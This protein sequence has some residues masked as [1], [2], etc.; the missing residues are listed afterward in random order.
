MSW[1]PLY[2][3]ILSVYLPGFLI[4][5]KRPQIWKYTIIPFFYISMFVFCAVGSCTVFAGIKIYYTTVDIEQGM[6]EYATLLVLQPILYYIVLFHYAY[7]KRDLGESTID[8][9]RFSDGAIS[10]LLCAYI[11]AAMIYYY[12]AVGP[13]LIFYVLSGDLANDNTVAMR[14]EFLY[15]VEYWNLINVGIT[16]FPILLLMHSYFIKMNDKIQ[17][18]RLR[19]FYF[20]VAS[21]A[22]I[23]SGGKSSIVGIA[24]FL[25]IASLVNRKL[26][27]S[28]ASK[29]ILNIKNM[30]YASIVF[31]FLFTAYYVAWE[32]KIDFY[33][34][35][36]QLYYRICVV[37][38]EVIAASVNYA[39]ENGYFGV[40]VLPTIQGLLS[41]TQV[42]LSF[43]MMD[44]VSGYKNAG[45]T[46]VPFV[47]EGYLGF[48]WFGAIIYCVVSYIGLIIV[49][50]VLNKI[51][52]G[53]FKYTLTAYYCYAS[54]QL[55]YGGISALFSLTNVSFFFGIAMLGLILERSFSRPMV[56]RLAGQ[57]Q[58]R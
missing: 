28:N 44:Y 38:T 2:I 24:A 14:V 25:A 43:T 19:F 9:Y 7:N 34:F 51:R 33:G 11:I 31:I 16:T 10:V 49:Q 47:A 40:T 17:K 4:L 32:G 50:E 20:A 15:G 23:S 3:I 37:Y 21:A 52:F 5:R 8:S 30:L 55:S 56:G 42:N 36:V 54:L 39:N 6:L 29:K 27:G 18:H 26:L 13:F 35:L 12:I 48:G 41:H 46:N 45:G 53:M 1:I 22:V 58:S 57:E